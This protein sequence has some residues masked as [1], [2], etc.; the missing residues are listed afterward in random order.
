M[1]R[2]RSEVSGWLSEHRHLRLKH[3]EARI[4]SCRGHFD[5]LGHRI[6][7]HDASPLPRARRRFQRM[8]VRALDP[9][10]RG[11]RRPDL[12]SSIASSRGLLLP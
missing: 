4:L 3:P 6:R 1:R 5:A 2:Y 8:L 11:D 7:R 12:E 10:R 9:P